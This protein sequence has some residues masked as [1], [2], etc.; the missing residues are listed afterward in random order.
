MKI[1][2]KSLKISEHLSEET[3][4]F[5]ANVYADGK[6]IAYARN[7]GHG[8]C[9]DIHC[10]HKN[11]DVFDAANKYCESLPDEKLGEYSIK[12]NLETVVDGLV[13]KASLDKQNKAHDTKMKRD[14]DKGLCF[15]TREDYTI[16]SWKGHKLKDVIQ[17]PLGRM[18][19]VNAITKH[20][21]DK[22]LNTNIPKEILDLVN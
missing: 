21:K 5:T 19:I 22:L 20:G 10:E 16:V 9:T 8:G 12:Q 7:S 15:G 14:F 2:L 13:Y 11:K 1:E 3:T 4:A 6:L 17:N 18:P